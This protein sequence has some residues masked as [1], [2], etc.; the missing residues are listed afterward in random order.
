MT[1]QP[2]VYRKQGGDELVVASGGTLDVSAGTIKLPSSTL[3]KGFIQLPITAWREIISD[4]IGVAADAA[5][6]GSGAI[7]ASDTTP[8][9]G[10]VNTATDVQLRLSWAATNV[11]AVTQQFA[12]PPDLDDTAVVT[13][14]ILGTTG[15][16]MDSVTVTVGYVENG[17][18]V[19]A[20]DSD[21]GGATA[22]IGQN[23]TLS[24]VT[25][26]IAAANVGAYP[27]SATVT[28][29]PGTHANDALYV[30]ATWVEYTRKTS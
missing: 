18:G 9:L 8:I 26:D 7:L 17:T 24:K 4:E 1:Y 10:R 11:D 23:G 21:A 5:A 28:L 16:A 6:R 13:V 2:K 22:A 25:R 3:A 19:Y 14:C 15:G 27:R 29:T 30:Y 20:A 12:F